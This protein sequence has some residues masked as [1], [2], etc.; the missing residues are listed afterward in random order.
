MR[1]EPYDVKMDARAIEELPI[2]AAIQHPISQMFLKWSGSEE[3]ELYSQLA[4]RLHFIVPAQLQPF[5][6]AIYKLGYVDGMEQTKQSVEIW[7]PQQPK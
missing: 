3:M 6:G 5:I 7:Y 1:P 4:P 2:L